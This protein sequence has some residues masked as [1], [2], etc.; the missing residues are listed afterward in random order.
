MD[1]LLSN[2]LSTIYG[3]EQRD[4]YESELEFFKKNP[5][6]AGMASEDNRIVINPFSKL[7]ER[8]LDA[9]RMNEAARVYVRTMKLPRF[10]LTKEQSE[11]LSGTAYE[12]APSA[13]RKA[14][15]IARII[16]GDPSAGN[17]TDEQ[18]SVAAMVMQMMGIKP[19]G[20]L[21]Q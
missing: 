12:S 18:K 7:S 1:G 9:V 10:S 20:L 15:L 5:S 4:P 8:E 19:K 3:V 6:V 17:A 21:S 11:T 13:D 16:S 2:K 14:T